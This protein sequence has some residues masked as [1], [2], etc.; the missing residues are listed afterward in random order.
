VLTLTDA[1]ATYRAIKRR[2]SK[3]VAAVRK[4]YR[5]F[6]YAWIAEPNRRDTG[7]HVLMYVHVGDATLSKAV[8]ERAWRRHLELKRAPAHAT[9][10]YFGYQMKCLTDREQAKVFL[11]LNGSSPKRQYL[12]HA[13]NRF[14]RDGPG[15]E[16]LAR[17]EAESLALKRVR[18]YLARRRL[19]LEPKARPQ[20]VGRVHAGS[21]R[22]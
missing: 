16:Q 12:V 20:T 6:A 14:W 13:S 15:G 2:L 5:T 9:I 3:F 1:G 10:H 21:A 4:V 18:A 7:N 22:C 11:R 8:V 19:G 17:A